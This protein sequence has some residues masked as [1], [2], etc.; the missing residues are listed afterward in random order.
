MEAEAPRCGGPG[1]LVT[2]RFIRRHDTP[3]SR[4]G[5]GFAPPTFLHGMA[6]PANHTMS[7][8]TMRRSSNSKC[9]VRGNAGP[10][11]QPSRHPRASALSAGERSIQSGP[12][13]FPANDADKRGFKPRDASTWPNSISDHE[14]TRRDTNGTIC[15]LRW[16][17][18]R[19]SA[20]F[21]GKID[22]KPMLL[23]ADL[24][25][26]RGEISRFPFAA[27]RTASALAAARR[28]FAI[29]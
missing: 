23:Y 22:W 20:P 16:I 21:A 19:A 1:R 27:V 17:Y 29:A 25:Q 8:G 18:P 10:R 24:A 26:R 13:R 12:F 5:R 15:L 4:V 2:R 3:G 6:V 28:L 14:S 7:I 9:A 11:S